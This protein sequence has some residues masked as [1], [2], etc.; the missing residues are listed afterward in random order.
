MLASR[1]LPPTEACQTLDAAYRIGDSGWVVLV[2]A[3]G[4]GASHPAAVC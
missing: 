4:R 2:E 3:C 1:T